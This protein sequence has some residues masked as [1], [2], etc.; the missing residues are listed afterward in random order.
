[1]MTRNIDI[2]EMYRVRDLL[3]ETLCREP[4]FKY[5]EKLSAQII[6]IQNQ[7]GDFRK[8]LDFIANRA[9]IVLEPVVE[10]DSFEFPRNHVINEVSITFQIEIGIP[11]IKA[12]L[13]L[14]AKPLSKADIAAG[15]M[16][17]IQKKSRAL[18]TATAR[19]AK[20]LVG[21]LSQ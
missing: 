16:Y 8:L 7:K 9:M 1:M 20:Q 10:S 3:T 13:G 6:V 2:E 12:E 17:L 21:A 5:R 19:F 11:H 18:P 15:N 4:K 14:T